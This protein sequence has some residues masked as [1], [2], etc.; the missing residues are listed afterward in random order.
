MPPGY[1][2][3]MISI[4][5]Y[6]E[7]RAPRR[8]RR[9]ALANPCPLGSGVAA[10][11]PACVRVPSLAPWLPPRN[12]R[13]PTPVPPRYLD[14]RRHIKS[15]PWYLRSWPPQ[16]IGVVRVQCR[17]HELQLA[18]AA[19]ARAAGE[20]GRASWL[21]HRLALDVRFVNRQIKGPSAARRAAWPP[22]AC[23][24]A[25]SAPPPGHRRPLPPPP[26]PSF[27]APS[28]PPPAHP[29]GACNTAHS[30]QGRSTRC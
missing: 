14:M 4:D 24:A 10:L 6:G 23:R 26:L 2:V 28:A 18:A 21:M 9:S 3:W 27:R 29:V 8:V 13:L 16:V 15:L 1:Q 20:L 11:P 19:Q 17:G 30:R 7:L 25:P 22:P 12:T 5:R